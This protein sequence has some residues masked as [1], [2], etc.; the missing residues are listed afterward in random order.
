MK[1]LKPVKIEHQI[2]EHFDSEG[3]SLGFLTEDENL[4]FR[5]QIAENKAEGYYLILNGE[6]I[7]ILP[8]GS[9]DKCIKGL[10]DTRDELYSRL[11]K[12]QLKI[13]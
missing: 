5:A 8:D 9:E 13:T 4:E 10:Y 7:N 3:N 6:R 12:E 2:I 11:F 1:K